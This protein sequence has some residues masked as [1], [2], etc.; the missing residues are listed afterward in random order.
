MEVT[1]KYRHGNFNANVECIQKVQ[2]LFAY[3]DKKVAAVF[4]ISIEAISEIK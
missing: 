1:A 2:T 4:S 3:K